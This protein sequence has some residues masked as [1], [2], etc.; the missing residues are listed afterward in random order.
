[1][2]AAVAAGKVTLSAGEPWYFH[3]VRLSTKPQMARACNWLW[4]AGLIVPRD[5]VAILTV[6]GA[7]VLARWDAKRSSAVPV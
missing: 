4:E 6:D 2:L 3:G 7:T 1:M 5:G